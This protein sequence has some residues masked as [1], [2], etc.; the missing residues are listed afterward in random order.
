[1]KF[2]EKLEE[3]S[4][5]RKKALAIFGALFFVTSLNYFFCCSY[6]TKF[7]H[8]AG[9]KRNNEL[10]REIARRWEH[11]GFD[12]VEL[13]RYDILLSL[14]DP[15]NPSSV[16]I[17][18]NEGRTR[19]QFPL[20]EKAVLPSEESPDVLPPFLTVTPNG[21]VMGDVVYANFG[22]DE[23]FEQLIK[24]GVSLK[25]HIVI[26]RQGRIFRGN[27]VHNAEIHG[28]IGVLI[29]NDP[30]EFAPDGTDNTFPK[31][32]WL[33]KT[34]VQ[35][36][37]A[38]RAVS[39]GDISTYGYPSVRGIYRKPWKTKLR[40]RIPAHHI[41]FQD[42][43]D[44]FSRLKGPRAPDSWQGGLNI[45][46]RVGPGFKDKETKIKMVVGSVMVK[47]PIY[48]VIGTITGTQDSDRYVLLGNHRDAWVY[49]ASDPSSGTAIMMELSR[50]VGELLKSGWR[51]RRTIKFCS[52]DAEEQFIAGSTEWVEDN[53]AILRSRAVAYLNLD[54]G[55]GGNF[56]FN[57]DGSPLIEDVL[58]ST[59][60][61]VLDPT[62][63]SE[64]AS[65]YDVMMERDVTKNVNHKPVVQNLAFGSDYVAFYHFLGVTSGDFTYIFGGTHGIRRSYPVYHSIHDT[66]YWLKTFV[67]PNFK[68][69]LAVGQYASRL[70]MKF[71]D[72]VFLP[73]NPTNYVPILKKQILHLKN[74]PAFKRHDI[75]LRALS[76]AVKYF[77]NNSILFEKA[78]SKVRIQENR[79]I[80]RTLNNQISNLERAF[81]NTVEKYDHFLFD[82]VIFGPMWDNIYSGHYFPRVH[83]AIQ[84]ASVKGDWEN[85]KKE[86]SV[87]LFAI[88]SAAK[89][90]EPL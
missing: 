60:R 3:N 7:P 30:S 83:E 11:Y 62:S 31:T 34:G 75:D 38:S 44:I 58:V 87:V 21:T 22:R 17:V 64:G 56:T 70:L 59:A 86:I 43:L 73:M 13:A 18:D 55:V 49:G 20:K 45:T 1:M 39:P 19:L 4:D 9:S 65:M 29:Y 14:P 54:I 72:S 15:N 50:G 33:P 76:N 48:N 24:Q 82:N 36:G 37:S 16:S 77:Q 67:D 85:V 46:Y 40:S 8:I 51:P 26:I 78:R 53:A 32:W 6:L 57:V 52:W 23:D 5:F 42:A 27:K 88:R 81:I 25:D 35:R 89:V 84:R 80:I 47:K 10:A 12:K 79:S 74:N 41:S 63:E 90:L 68:I 71:V 28:A 2:K 61:E 66:Y 69:H